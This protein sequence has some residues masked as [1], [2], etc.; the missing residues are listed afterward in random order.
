MMWRFHDVA[1]LL[2]KLWPSMLT[3]IG[4]PW[5]AEDVMAQAQHF[6]LHVWKVSCAVD[7]MAQAQHFQ[8]RP[9]EDFKRH[10]VGTRHPCDAADN[11]ATAPYRFMSAQSFPSMRRMSWLR[12]SISSYMSGR[13]HVSR[14]FT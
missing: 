12:R 1:S 8:L 3:G 13:S 5:H 7:V 9:S 2:D 10:L 4:F 11:M 6:Q 14:R